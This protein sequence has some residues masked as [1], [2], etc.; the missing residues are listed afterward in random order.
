MR[1][2]NRWLRSVL[3]QA[4]WAAIKVKD[5]DFGTQFR[6][7]AKRRGDQRA[8]IA[9]AHSLLTVIYYVLTRGVPDQDPGADLSGQD[10]QQRAGAGLGRRQDR[11]ALEGIAPGS[12]V[13][14]ELGQ[15]PGVDAQAWEVVLGQVDE[16][17]R[18]LNQLHRS[19]SRRA[20]RDWGRGGRAVR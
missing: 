12:E 19:V 3:L 16:L 6:R 11:Q 7:I 17:D 2:G 8:A 9:V 10:H 1:H 13:P 14:T 20:P 5:G 15:Q 4:A 18:H